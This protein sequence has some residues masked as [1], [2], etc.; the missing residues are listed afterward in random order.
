[1]PPP[2]RGA[3]DGF[4]NAAKPKDRLAIYAKSNELVNGL[5]D[6]PYV[7]SQSGIDTQAF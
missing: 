4:A 2:I 5:A 6:T 3:D 7:K 1:L